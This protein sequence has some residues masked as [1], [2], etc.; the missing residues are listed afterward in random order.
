[1]LSK[2]LRDKERS[3]LAAF[4]L[5]FLPVLGLRLGATFEVKDGITVADLVPEEDVVVMSSIW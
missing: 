3:S 1:V 5:L 2:D 4:P